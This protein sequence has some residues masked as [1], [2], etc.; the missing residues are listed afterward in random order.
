MGEWAPIFMD[1]LLNIVVRLLRRV[2]V[3]ISTNKRK[4]MSMALEW[5]VQQAHIGMMIKIGRAHV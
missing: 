5:D 4:L 2:E 1:T 3:V